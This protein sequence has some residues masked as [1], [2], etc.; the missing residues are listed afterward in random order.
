MVRF[1]VGSLAFRHRVEPRHIV[2]TRF[3]PF[4][5]FAARRH[6]LAGRRLFQN[7]VGAP[8]QGFREFVVAASAIVRAVVVLEGPA[9]GTV[10]RKGDLRQPLQPLRVVAVITFQIRISPVRRRAVRSFFNALPMISFEMTGPA[11]E[12]VSREDAQS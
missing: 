10:L 7:L 12:S 1:G 4:P 9:H 2:A 8:G 5:E 6:L 3:Q 11:K